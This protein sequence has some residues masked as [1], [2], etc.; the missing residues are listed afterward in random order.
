MGH[1]HNES[2]NK[3]VVFLGNMN[4]LP[5]YFASELKK[6]GIDITFIVD[7]DKNNLLDRPESW[8]NKLA[9][10]YP[11]WIK[12][13]L[14]T[15][16]LKAFKFSLPLI[17]LK[18]YINLINQ[19][20][21]IFLNGFWISLA[22]YI[23]PGKKVVAVFAGYE[24]DI[25]ANY[26]SINYLCDNFYQ[27]SATLKKLIP[28]FITRLLFKKLIELQQQ[29]IKNTQVIN[30]YPT[31]INPDADKL[32]NEIKAGQ[33]FKRLELRG[34]DCDKFPYREPLAENKKF[35]ILNVTR[36]FYLNNRNDNKRNDI[37]IKGI[38]RFLKSNAVTPTDVEILFFEK[39][40]DLAEAKV[41]CDQYGLT[42]FINWQQQTSVEEL[43][44]YFAACDVAFDQ[45]GVQWV[46]AGLFS[47]LTGRPL[48]ANGRPD[49]FE[50]LTN[51][52]SPICQ[53]N[54]EEEVEVWLTKLYKER[55]LIKEIGIT[56]RN[57]V[58]RHYNINSTI[59]YFV[60]TLQLQ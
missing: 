56:S 15:N 49:V 46:G 35:T 6:R 16:N 20:D 18:R 11:E 50:K 1:L 4:N 47:M 3:K 59:D 38:G 13:I 17:Y 26:N 48:I 12:E 27:S 8:D 21:I 5:Y 42:P 37:M 45:L 22:K 28:R 30:Y 7:A 29:G 51:E 44:N 14:L 40:D 2:K 32:L 39:G 43:N 25:L 9:N 19:Y 10:T 36:F 55:Y 58:L 41:L 57:Y 23:K 53:A 60:E 33:I 31:G 24:L 52:K 34:F 54:S